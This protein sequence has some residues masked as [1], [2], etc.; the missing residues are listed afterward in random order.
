MYLGRIMELASV[1]DLFDSPRHPY[2]QALLSAVP[3]ADPDVEATRQRTILTG[4]VPSPAKPPP[5]CVFSTRCPLA[6]QG[7]KDKCFSETP[8]WRELE[9]DRFVACHFAE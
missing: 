9:K 8:Q 1:K 7:E 2:T 5:G 3:V 6:K 4:D